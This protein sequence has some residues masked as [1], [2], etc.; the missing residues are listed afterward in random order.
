MDL[1][2]LKGKTIVISGGGSGIGLEISTLFLELGAHVIVLSRKLKSIDQGLKLIKQQNPNLKNNFSSFECDMSD[3]TVVDKT[4]KKI[5]S[6]FKNIDIMIN[7]CSTWSLEEINMLEQ[8][9]IDYHYNNI[10]KSVV[11][12]TKY[13][14]KILSDNSSI[15]NIGSFSGLLPMKN[16]SIY[17]SLKT[18]VITFTKSS[19][20]EFGK[21][22]IRVNCVIPGVIRT[23]MTSNY[24]DNNYEKI[25][26]PI[27][28]GRIGTT[29]DVANCV[30]FLCSDFSS[31]I[32]GTSIEVTGGKYLTQL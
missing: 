26:K 23:P 22:G 2:D 30:T 10:F 7:N 20:Q 29:R 17:S 18:S 15:V 4:F 5:K 6:K 14:S 19:A 16:A 32:T 13:S 27:A 12:G 8:K 1:F 25:I 31:Y 9:K 24:I 21:S 11:L 28:L 3:E